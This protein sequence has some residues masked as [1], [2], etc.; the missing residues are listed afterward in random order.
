MVGLT[1][2]E[3]NNKVIQELNLNIQEIIILKGVE[4]FF[5]NKNNF[6]ILQ[7]IVDG[8]NTISRRTIEYF[9]TKYS[10]IKNTT[11]FIE[12]LNKR[13]KFNVYSSYK[14]KLKC[15]KKK[16]FDPFGRGDRIPFFSNNTCIITTIGQLNFYK[17]FITN[18]IYKYCLE[19]HKEIQD[20]LLQNFTKNK[21]KSSKKNYNLYYKNNIVK[22]QY[23]MPVNLSVTFDV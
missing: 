9:V 4:E 21:K 10:N 23:K 11:Y 13:I 14:D 19:N 8:N 6:N 22:N 12:N 20:S 1:I 16:Y 15:H 3:N 18:D 7:T 5:N 2:D 17:W